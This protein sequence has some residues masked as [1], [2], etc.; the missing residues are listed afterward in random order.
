MS[1]VKERDIQDMYRKSCICQHEVFTPVGN[2]DILTSTRIIEIK[3]AKEW[4]HGVGQLLAYS[5]FYPNHKKVLHL[6]NVDYL[7]R[8]HQ[9]RRHIYNITVAFE[10]EVL[11][12]KLNT[13]VLIEDTVNELRLQT[14]VIE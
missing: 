2:I 12:D 8:K 5:F 4:K 6:Y 1:Y 7:Y 13:F 14:S 9:L 3:Q 11:L 10:I